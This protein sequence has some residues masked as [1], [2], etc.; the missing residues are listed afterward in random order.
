MAELCCKFQIPTSNTVGGD[1]ETRT[2]LQCDMVQNMYVIQWDV[3]LQYDLEQ[4]CVSF[5]HMS[6]AY[7][8]C[9]SSF[10]YLHQILQ[11]ELRRQ[12]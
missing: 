7:L 5:M 1:A 3:I 12:E 8:N 2:V 4:N 10:K 11:E 9:V 6:N